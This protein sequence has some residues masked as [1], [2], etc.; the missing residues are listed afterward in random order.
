[1]NF[2]IH[3]QA[4]ENYGAHAEDGKFANGNAYWKWKNGKTYIVEGVEREQDAVA[5]VMA[6]MVANFVLTIP[7]VSAW[8]RPAFE[9]ILVAVRVTRGIIEPILAGAN[10][11]VNGHRRV[12]T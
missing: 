1:M 6:D 12:A 9:E 4:I 10:V 11:L 2:V 5:F 7:T 3:T 8:R